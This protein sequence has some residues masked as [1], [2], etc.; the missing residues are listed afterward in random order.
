MKS[1]PKTISEMVKFLSK[2][3]KAES[4]RKALYKMGLEEIG[5]GAYSVCFRFNNYVIKVSE[6]DNFKKLI[7]SF[8]KTK[9]FKKYCVPV[10]WVHPKGISVVCSYIEIDWDNLYHFDFAEK[11]RRAFKKFNVSLSDIHC[12]NVVHCIY[13]GRKCQKLLDYGCFDSA[14]D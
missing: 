14:F 12:E 9:L 4:L 5:N 7:G 11:A 8:Y 13:R 6:L 1:K 3:N 10:K 2:F